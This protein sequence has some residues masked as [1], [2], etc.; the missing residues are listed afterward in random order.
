[1]SKDT[2]ELSREAKERGFKIYKGIVNI[3]TIILLILLYRSLY[4]TF[5]ENHWLYG[6]GVFYFILRLAAFAR[7][8]RK[9]YELDIP[10][11]EYMEKRNEEIRQKNND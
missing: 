4:I 7:R 5:D 1:M 6:L 10:V 3:F 8:E 2:Q 11:T 9:A